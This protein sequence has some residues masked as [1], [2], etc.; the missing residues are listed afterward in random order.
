MCMREQCYA[1]SDFPDA[2]DRFEGNTCL[3]QLVPICLL[4]KSSH[5]RMVMVLYSSNA[6]VV[7]WIELRTSKP[8]MGVRF[9]PGAQMYGY[10]LW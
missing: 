7:Q 2:V 9:P 4:E 10:M 5:A 1:S 3:K 6:P 8:L